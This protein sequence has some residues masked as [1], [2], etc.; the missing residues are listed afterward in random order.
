MMHCEL[1]QKIPEEGSDIPTIVSMGMSYKKTNMRK[2][3]VA[4][5]LGGG[6]LLTSCTKTRDCTPG[7][8]VPVFISYSKGDMDTIV[9]RRFVTGTNFQQLV[10]S[11]LLAGLNVID[12]TTVGDSTYVSAKTNRLFNLQPGHDYEIFVPSTKYL[13]QITDIVETNKQQ[14]TTPF[15]NFCTSTIESFKRDGIIQKDLYLYIR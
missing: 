4:L 11:M 15:D 1:I 2:I 9:Y 12:P 10:D 5:F 6:G 8:V 14:K 7:S 13:A 3:L